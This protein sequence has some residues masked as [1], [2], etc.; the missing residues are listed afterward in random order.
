MNYT[1]T[2]LASIY[3]YTFTVLLAETYR[4]DDDD[5]DEDDGPGIVTD[6]PFAPPVLA[7]TG[8]PC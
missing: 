2:L 5:G 8:H 3:L 7:T 1:I 4:Y 6:E